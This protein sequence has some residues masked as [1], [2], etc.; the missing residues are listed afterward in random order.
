MMATSGWQNATGRGAN[1]NKELIERL[2]G[3]QRNASNCSLWIEAAD[4]IEEQQ[5]WI[6]SLEQYAKAADRMYKELETE[7]AEAQKRIDELENFS[8][9]INHR[10]NWVKDECAVYPDNADEKA[11]AARIMSVLVREFPNNLVMSYREIASDYQHCANQ[12]AAA[13]AQIKVLREALNAA[14]HPIEPILTLELIEEALAQPTD[15]S[16]LR[17]ML[18]AEREKAAKVCETQTDAL[19]C[20]DAIRAMGSES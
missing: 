3:Y 8:N 12:L 11:F 6:T 17:E 9:E 13:Q 20:A 4:T 5:S 2:R 19:S 15:D 16:A 7:L 18:A 10:L 1:V 14:K